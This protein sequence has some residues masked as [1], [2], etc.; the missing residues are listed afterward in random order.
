MTALPFATVG[1]DNFPAVAGVRNLYR[2]FS[3]AISRDPIFGPVI[4]V[5]ESLVNRP[6]AAASAHTFAS[7]WVRRDDR[8]QLANAEFFPARAGNFNENEIARLQRRSTS[9]AE[10]NRSM[11]AV[12]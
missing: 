9:P 7:G 5:R 11:N 12:C 4:H 8:L 1:S 10:N 3:F 6:A 2:V